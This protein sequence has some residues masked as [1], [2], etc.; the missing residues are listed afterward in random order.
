MYSIVFNSIPKNM[1]FCS[2]DIL[3]LFRFNSFIIL[4][5]FIGSSKKKIKNNYF[6]L[7]KRL[8]FINKIIKILNII[9]NKT[10]NKD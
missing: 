3:I 2:P 8:L 9:A 7:N 5:K 6:P 1:N 4:V 10:K